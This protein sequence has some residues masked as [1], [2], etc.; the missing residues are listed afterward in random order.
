MNTFFEEILKKKRIFDF[1]WGLY[2]KKC[3]TKT[4]YFLFFPP[5]NTCR[6]EASCKQLS[7]SGIVK[8]GLPP[9]QR[10]A[11]GGP[12]RIESLRDL[13]RS[14]EDLIRLGEDLIRLGEALVWLVQ[15]LTRLGGD[16]LYG[17][18][19]VMSYFSSEGL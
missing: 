12:N 9:F 14:G 16:F 6:F 4:S 2:T 7:P 10:D 18:G 17:R 19:S 15:D 5:G 3:Y 1:F 8:I 13:I 11:V